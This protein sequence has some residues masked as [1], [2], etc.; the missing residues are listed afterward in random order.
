MELLKSFGRSALLA[1][2]GALLVLLA[3]SN[4]LEL[5]PLKYAANPSV[6]ARILLACLGVILV[7]VAL[8][9]EWRMQRRGAQ[10]EPQAEDDAEKIAADRFF[11]TLDDLPAFHV[12]TAGARRISI[13]GR[14]AVNILTSYQRVFR[15]LCNAGCEVR[16]IFVDP[17]ADASRYLY[18]SQFDV[19]Q[20]NLK[21][22]V[23]QI[24]ALSA[25]IGPRLSVRTTSDVPSFSLVHIEK[26]DRSSYFRVQLNFMHSRIGRDRPVFIVDEGDGW[27]AA[28]RDEFDA[29]WHAGSS[30][31]GE[32]IL[33]ELE[34]GE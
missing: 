16:L 3:L 34:R 15:E 29:M 14:T 17:T 21:S 7:V 30:F 32:A 1:L 2:A 33:G 12:E 20:S 18:G 4:G 10:P 11:R 6:V 19:Y 25:D 8:V 9:T 13:L 24:V 22:A 27:Y 23:G 5:G 31:S 26:P 28:F